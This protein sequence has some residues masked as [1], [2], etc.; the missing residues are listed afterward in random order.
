MPCN[1]QRLT[2]L[3]FLISI[4]NKRVKVLHKVFFFKKYLVF[5]ASFKLALDALPQLHSGA[6]KK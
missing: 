4:V 1:L 3:C 6:D 2:E 5:R